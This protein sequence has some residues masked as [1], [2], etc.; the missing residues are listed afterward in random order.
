MVNIEHFT[1][2]QP[3]PSLQQHLVHGLDTANYGWREYGN[4][5]AVWR[6]VDL[7]AE[8]NMPATAA[9]NAEVCLRHPEI[10]EAVLTHG[11]DVLGHGWNN[12]IRQY[13]MS[14]AEEGALV[15]RSVATLTQAT[16]QAVL[17]WLTPGFAVSEATEEILAEAGLR[18]TADRCDDDRPYWLDTAAGRLLA[19]PYSLETNDI[20]LFLGLHYT[21][22]EFADALVDHVRRLCVEQRCDTVVALGLHPFLVGHPGRIDRLRAALCRIAELPQVWLTT[23]TDIYQRIA[24][25]HGS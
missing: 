12:S 7:F 11:W 19:I 22:A 17:G 9:L 13:A 3:G 16:G 1:P 15:R 24:K 23:G 10:T 5:V 2:G 20:S 4:R 6:L 18:F 25:E 14:R 21:A 8:L